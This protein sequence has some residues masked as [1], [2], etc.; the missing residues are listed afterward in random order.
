M[1]FGTRRRHYRAEKR[2]QQLQQQKAQQKSQ[3][4][5]PA[6]VAIPKS[7]QPT[8]APVPILPTDL[9]KWN[10]DTMMKSNARYQVLVMRKAQQQKLNLIPQGIGVA[11]IYNFFRNNVL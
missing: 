11:T 7:T 10:M 3:P 5:I 2:H 9:N 6:P 1:P 8:T 4:I